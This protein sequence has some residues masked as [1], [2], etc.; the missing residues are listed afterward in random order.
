[1]VSLAVVAEFRSAGNLLGRYGGGH[2]QANRKIQ[3]WTVPRFGVGII[4]L[5]G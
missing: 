4:L 3:M 2:W 5:G 1:M